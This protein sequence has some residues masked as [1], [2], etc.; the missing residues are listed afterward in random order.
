MPTPLQAFHGTNLVGTWTNLLFYMMEIILAGKF[1]SNEGGGVYRYLVMAI[2]F[3]ST[4]CTLVICANTW[5]ILL[6]YSTVAK[7]P[8]TWSLPLI[9]MSMGWTLFLERGF[10]VHNLHLLVRCKVTSLILFVLALAPLVCYMMS[11][12]LLY[13]HDMPEPEPRLSIVATQIGHSIG[14]AVDI[15]VAGALLYNVLKTKTFFRTTTQTRVTQI[16]LGTVATGVFSAITGILLL[17]LYYKHEH[18]FIALRLMASR[19]YALTVLVDLTW[20]QNSAKSATGSTRTTEQS[21]PVNLATLRFQRA[22]VVHVDSEIGTKDVA[23]DLTTKDMTYNEEKSRLDVE[24]DNNRI[25][26][27]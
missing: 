1:L 17:I 23:Q 5:L 7:L 12:I 21:A 6:V 10:L 3:F 9:V 24:G 20:M 26:S 16:F 4:L 22:T 2:A 15:I 11:G 19:I 25:Y 18:G 27:S 8:N 13:I 14:M